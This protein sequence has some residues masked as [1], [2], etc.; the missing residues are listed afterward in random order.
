MSRFIMFSAAV[1]H[2]GDRYG[3]VRNLKG[4]QDELN[5]RRSKA[6]FMSN[7]TGLYVQKGSVDDVERARRERA[8]PDGVVEYNTGFEKPQDM[9]NS[10]SLT[11]H[12]ALMQDARQEIDSFANINPALMTQNG[13][14]EHSGV[15]INLLQKAGIAELGSFLRNYKDWK[16]RVYRAIWNIVVRTWQAERWI[17]TTDNQGLAQFIQI[18]GLELDQYG[19]PTIINAI[20]ALNVEMDLDEGPDEASLMQDTY[21]QIKTDPNVPFSV[22]LEFMLMAENK[23]LKIRQL[24]SQGPSPQQIQAIQLE[25]E[26]KQADIE[27]KRAMTVDR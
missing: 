19:M 20:G 13:Q 22:K 11:N 7:A 17:R 21:D 8:R 24:M 18:N 2:E 14:D 9:L 26:G 16:W 5:Q 15:A 25:L 27:N 4:P 23:K 6:L 1:D 10:E 12:L 3:F